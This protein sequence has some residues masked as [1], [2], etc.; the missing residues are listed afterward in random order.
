[1]NA[2]LG[3][4]LALEVQAATLPLVPHRSGSHLQRAVVQVRRPV[5]R[6]VAPGG[7]PPE[8]ALSPLNLG[9]FVQSKYIIVII[10]HCFDNSSRNML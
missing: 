5:P 4:T 2:S 10:M 9:Q 7:R 6:K 3:L 1:M 8:P